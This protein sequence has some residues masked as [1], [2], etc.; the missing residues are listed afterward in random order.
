MFREWLHKKS[1]SL[2]TY[3]APLPNAYFFFLMQCVKWRDRT[4]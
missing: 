3:D 1:E 4:G 2:T